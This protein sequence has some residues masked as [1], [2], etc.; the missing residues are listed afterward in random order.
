VDLLLRYRWPGNIRELANTLES[1][2]VTA[3]A[4]SIGI[5]QL[6]ARIRE[7][8]PVAAKG[9]FQPQ[10]YKAAMDKFRREY[11]ARMLEHAKGDLRRA[12][13]LAGVN[14]STF[15]RNGSKSGLTRQ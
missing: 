8:P 1:A 4:S 5:E 7:A 11:A 9:V 15:Y 12:A 3:P 13:R 14:P 10:T 6:P 2:Y